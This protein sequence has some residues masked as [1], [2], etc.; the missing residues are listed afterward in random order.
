MTPVKIAVV[1]AGSANF[2]LNALATLIR[3]SRLRG[4]TLSLVDI[5]ARGLEL[6]LSKM[7]VERTGN[8]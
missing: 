3:S 4:S 8:S 5:D 1:G 2:G 7:V 6:I